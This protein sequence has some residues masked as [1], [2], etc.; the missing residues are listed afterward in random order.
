MEVKLLLLPDLASIGGQSIELL[1]EL[2]GELSMARVSLDIG[3][4]RKE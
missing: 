1:L 3:V 2:F 4:G